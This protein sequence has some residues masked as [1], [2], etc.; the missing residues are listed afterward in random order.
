MLCFIWY[1]AANEI[2]GVAFLE[3]KEPDI[4]EMVAT[5]GAV[6]KLLKLQGQVN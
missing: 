5:I 4:K 1:T 2:D 3:L 6:K